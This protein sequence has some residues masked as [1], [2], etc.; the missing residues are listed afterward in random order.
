M[1]SSLAKK[2]A[3]LFLISEYACAHV[4]V[5]LLTFYSLFAL[6]LFDSF[7]PLCFKPNF[8]KKNLPFVCAAGFRLFFVSLLWMR[9]HTTSSTSLSVTPDQRPQWQMAE[10][11]KE[12]RETSERNRRKN[13]YSLVV[14]QHSNEWNEKYLYCVLTFSSTSTP[15]T[16]FSWH[17]QK[18]CCWLLMRTKWVWFL[19]SRRNRLVF[20]N[21]ELWTLLRN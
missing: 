1:P 12:K 9:D 19:V 7:S 20:L 8:N 6:I 2:P 16:C 21:N 17:F 15:G 5:G 11:R 10:N 3:S 18:C 13:D 14:G 4:C